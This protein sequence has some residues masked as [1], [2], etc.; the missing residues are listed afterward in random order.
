MAAGQALMLLWRLQHQDQ[1]TWKP[2]VSLFD[3]MYDLML[4]YYMYDCIQ[5]LDMEQGDP[6]NSSVSNENLV[7]VFTVAPSQQLV[8]H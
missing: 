4:V 6:K 8:T 7:P 2:Q 5:G 1:L 3:Y